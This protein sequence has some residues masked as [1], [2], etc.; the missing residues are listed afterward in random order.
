MRRRAPSSWPA[1]A[2]AGRSSSSSGAAGLKRGDLIKVNGPLPDFSVAVAA[3]SCSVRGAG[4]SSSGPGA[5]GGAT[6]KTASV[7]CHLVVDESARISLTTARR[8]YQWSTALQ[9]SEGIDAQNGACGATHSWRDEGTL[10]MRWTY[11]RTAREDDSASRSTPP[12]LHARVRRQSRGSRWPGICTLDEGQGNPD[13]VAQARQPP[14]RPSSRRRELSA[15]CFF[16]PPPGGTQNCR[17]SCQPDRAPECCHAAPEKHTALPRA[18]KVTRAPQRI[19]ASALEHNSR[20]AKL[21]NRA[22]AAEA[23]KHRGNRQPASNINERR[24]QRWSCAAP[25]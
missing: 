2:P 16:N 5:S 4:S 6:E 7:S 24:P 17:E 14:P 25:P 20:G 1:R 9:R 10:K 8:P 22:Q 12:E 18:T 11:A 21:S 3:P 13:A 23:V 15:E 19:A